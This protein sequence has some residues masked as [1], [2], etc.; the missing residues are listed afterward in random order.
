MAGVQLARIG[1]RF[2]QDTVEQFRDLFGLFFPD[3]CAGCGQPLPRSGVPV[4]PLCLHRLPRTGFESMA[5]NPVEKL[6]RGR[7]P[8]QSAC[9]LFYFSRDSAMQSMIHTLKYHQAPELGC[10]LG[11]QA[12]EALRASGAYGNTRAIV[13][14]PLNRHKQQVRGYNQAE[15]IAAGMAEIMG[16]PVLTHAVEKERGSQSQ[17]RKNRTDRWQHMSGSFRARADILASYPEL[18][19]VDDVVTTGATLEACGRALLDAG[20][21]KLHLVTLAFA[22]R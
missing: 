3:P 1:Q 13:P 16:L 22:D 18:I 20:L 14:L 10:F 11:R 5:V 12:G 8:L 4:C 21:A 17:T 7:L 2:M 19:L 6:F 9:S 15:R